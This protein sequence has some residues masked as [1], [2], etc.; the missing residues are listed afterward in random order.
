MSPELVVGVDFGTGSA[1]AVVVDT[2]SGSI[3]GS[4]EAEYPR[5]TQGEYCDPNRAQFRQHPQDYL[6]A[7]EL[8]VRRA[9]EEA[10]GNASEHV[11]MCIRDSP[12]IAS[13]SLS[14]NRIK[15]H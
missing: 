1:R 10:G 7:L 6:E 9:L 5:W 15:R 2:R 3:I 14:L 4:G 11:K 8:C 12:S 13:A